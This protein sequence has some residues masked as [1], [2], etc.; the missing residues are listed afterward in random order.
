MKAGEQFFEYTLSSF[1]QDFPAFGESFRRFCEGE[2]MDQSKIFDVE[3]SLE[4]LIVNSFSYGNE[5]GPVEI[6]ALVQG[7]ELKVVI[8]DQAPPFDLLRN[9]SPPPEGSL[10]E[11]KPGGLGIHLVKNLN[12]RLEYSRSNQGNQITLFKSLKS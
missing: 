7:G 1:T 10:M 5:H 12:D 6:S 4:E 3:L 11:R 2:G 9:T 8:K